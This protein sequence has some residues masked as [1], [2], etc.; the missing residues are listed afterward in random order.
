VKELRNILAVLV[1][2]VFAFGILVTSVARTVAQASQ[3]FKGDLSLAKLVSTVTPVPTVTPKVDYYLAYPGILP[4][5]VLYPIKMVRDRIALFL[6]GDS[7][8]KSEKLLL[9]ADKRLGAAK[10]LIEGN[11]IELGISTLTKAEKYLDQAVDEAIKA[12]KAG[13]ETKDLFPRL[14]KAALKHKEVIGEVSVRIPSEAQ[15]VVQ[16]TLKH[17]QLDYEKAKNE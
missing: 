3:C 10:V 17:P 8:K 15:G 6:T 12:K 9:Y 14:A 7:V 11:K 16:E 2:L 13:K 5:H 4:D 1:T